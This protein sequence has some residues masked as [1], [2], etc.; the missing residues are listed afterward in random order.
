MP[1]PPF[2]HDPDVARAETPPGSFYGDPTSYRAQVELFARSWQVLLVPLPDRE[3][4]TPFTLLP[5]CL[6]EP[7]VLTRDA[8]G[9]ARCLSNVCTHRGAQAVQA[10]G[11]CKALRCGYH[12][13]RWGL[14]GC[15]RGAPGFEGAED[16]PRSTDD[17]ARLPLEG[18]G[19]LSFTCVVDGEPFASYREPLDRWLGGLPWDRAT[20]DPT[21][22]KDYPVQAH[23][24]L[25]VENYLEGFHIPYVHPGLAQALDYTDY[26]YALIPQGTVQI[27]RAKPGDPALELPAG[28]PAGEGVAGLYVWRFPN[29]M[30]NVY[31]WGLSL[32]RV[33]PTGPQS[34]R[35]RYRRWVWA[36][37]LQDQGA[38]AD[39]E[40]VECE[41]QAVVE[42]VQRG[43]LSRLYARGRYAP[44]HEAGTH[45]FHRL[46]LEALAG[47][48]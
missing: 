5:G 32:N 6:D 16:F 33:D 3:H 11:P 42:A 8:E 45:H 35:V 37:E 40:Q 20:F 31:P 17:L 9:S 46:V 43:I 38:G 34:C 12:G 2:S 29:L 30:L 26:G 24:A 7:L 44:K 47:G 21:G 25:Y 19:P 18:W 13:R 23:W 36:P 27:G 14:D 1:Q 48:A 10:A 15:L 28:H 39:L 22:T 41:D 4:A